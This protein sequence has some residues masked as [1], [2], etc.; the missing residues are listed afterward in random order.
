MKQT[1][2]NTMLALVFAGCGMAV[3]G[4][5][6]KTVFIENGRPLSVIEDRVETVECRPG[7]WTRGE[8]HLESRDDANVIF[9]NK[10][11]GPGDF[12]VSARVALADPQND[13]A[14]L[15]IPEAI[16]K[17]DFNREGK[18]VLQGRLTSKIS[19]PLA[20]TSDFIE[21]GKCFDV[22]IT[23]SSRNLKIFINDKELCSL[24]KVTRDSLGLVGLIVESGKLRISDFRAA[25]ALVDVPS[26]KEIFSTTAFMGFKKNSDGSYVDDC[27]R[28]R[29]P[30]L[31]VAPNKDL[32]AICEARHEG[33][34]HGN[35]DLFMK[36]SKDGGK[37]WS[38]PE[39]IYEEGGD[40]LITTGNP[41]PVVDE[42][43]GT[44]W[45]PLC[46]DN[47]TVLMTHSKDS[48]KTWA[49][50]TEIGISASKY[51]WRWAAT[52]PGVGIQMKRGKYK[53]RLVI[54]LNHMPATVFYS[55]DHGKSW[56]LGGDLKGTADESQVVE[57]VDGR[58]L[59]ESRKSRG[60]VRWS[61]SDDGGDCWEN[62]E[63]DKTIPAPL[64]QASLLHYSTAEDEGKNRILFCNPHHDAWRVNLAVQVSYDEGESWPVKKV[65]DP[66]SA[67]YSCMAVLPDG[68]IGV[69][70]EDALKSRLTFV[71]FSL[72]WLEQPD[73]LP[74][75]S[76]E[77]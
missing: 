41:C 9:G 16:W 3:A 69:L 73:S 11:V 76:A 33:G 42:D 58:L 56:T 39:S 30:A 20:E 32:L 50:P 4:E 43:T 66:G 8:G 28:F 12:E 24:G 67:Q 46:R 15:H 70:Y 22:K 38:R 26:D 44:I 2:R 45:L 48:G 55:D 47:R 49:K 17:L 62:H 57:L 29:I 65:I 63:P 61:V 37:T 35:I 71:R 54:P 36:R 68:D 51:K 10:I 40:K 59:M 52:G 53:G 60:S 27:K 34:D 31:I 1:I 75:D 19:K 25:G 23:R 72:D 13:V 7:R 21:P 14:Y 6:S 64:C 5:E 18:I 74:R 77:Q